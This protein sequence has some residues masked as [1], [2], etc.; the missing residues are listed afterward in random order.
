MGKIIWS[1][2]NW[3]KPL[4]RWRIA[5]MT[6]NSVYRGGHVQRFLMNDNLI[7]AS[8]NLVWKK[9]TSNGPAQLPAKSIDTREMVP[10][11]ND[12]RIV[13]ICWD[14][15][16]AVIAMSKH[17]NSFW[18]GM[19]IPRGEGRPV[20]VSR[21]THGIGG[22]RVKIFINN[23][24]KKA[25]SSV[26]LIFWDDEKSQLSSETEFLLYLCEKR[27]SIGQTLPK[28]HFWVKN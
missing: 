16:K 2:F 23:W 25:K 27:L 18:A 1:E 8:Q 19:F 5:R 9:P 20:L 4:G 13:S 10:V 3:G 24:G 28:R 17:N 21:T 22:A 14:R 7:S 26:A 12:I 11:W 6:E 15:T